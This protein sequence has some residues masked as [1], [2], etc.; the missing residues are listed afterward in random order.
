MF[1]SKGRKE[2]FLACEEL[3]CEISIC[4]ISWAPS[5]GRS[6]DLIA[7]ATGNRILI[8]RLCAGRLGALSLDLDTDFTMGSDV[9]RVEFSPSGLKI[10]ALC[11]KNDIWILEQRANGSWDCN[12]LMAA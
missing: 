2:W 5:N 1:G 11:G 7:T 9:T 10:A 4:S 6:F 8:W 3:R 12:E